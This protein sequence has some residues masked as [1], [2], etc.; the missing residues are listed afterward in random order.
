MFNRLRDRLLFW[1]LGRDLFY[2]LL[3][4]MGVTSIE[5]VKC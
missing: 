4:L 5:E 2:F 3:L 1:V